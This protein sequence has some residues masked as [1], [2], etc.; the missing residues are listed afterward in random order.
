M[1]LAQRGHHIMRAYD[2]ELGRLRTLVLDMKDRVI[3]QTQEA[4]SALL[5]PDLN[6]A[7]LVLDREPGIDTL[8]LEA[9]EEIFMLIAKRQPTAVDLRLV[10]AI[11]KVVNNLE[12]CGD[13]AVQ[14][15]RSAIQLNET[16]SHHPPA[17]LAKNLE[18]L[19]AEVCRVLS[20]AVGALAEADLT[21]AIAVFEAETGLYRQAA[22]AREQILD[23]QPSQAPKTLAEL[24]AIQHA[25]ERLGN[26]GA[27]IAEQAVYV[28]RGDDVRYRNRELLIDALRQAAPRA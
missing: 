12:R 13:H 7:R 22:S 23:S 15:A 9:D 10:M 24:L 16:D 27:N 20:K 3:A 21:Q 4:L 8:T 5:E 1:S 25:L 28:I 2:L 26:H 19:A 18:Q 6:A 17:T 14:I 11:S